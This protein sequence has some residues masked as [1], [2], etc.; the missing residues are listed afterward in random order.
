MLK[1][2]SSGLRDISLPST[3]ISARKDMWQTYRSIGSLSSSEVKKN[4]NPII[5]EERRLY[6]PLGLE[7][8]KFSLYNNSSPISF[9]DLGYDSNM[10][11]SPP[12]SFFNTYLRLNYYD[13]QDP[14][15]KRLV[16]Q[17]D[18]PFSYETSNV[19]PASPVFFVSNKNGAGKRHG[20][21]LYYFDVE[22]DVDLFLETLFLDARV[23]RSI[24]LA[25][26]NAP[27]SVEDI[28][29]AAFIKIPVYK[30]SGDRFYGLDGQGKEFV[31]NGEK[32]EIKLF[33]IN[34]L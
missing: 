1:I 14:S 17:A 26:Y 4:I 21:Y 30:I 5:D 15:S 29:F 18:L 33:E 34:V 13:S 28:P 27:V 23:G 10:L 12:L 25:S 19:E 20:F 11:S 32:L 31:H 16:Y 3:Y 24:R 8:I 22:G 9:F 6:A 7:E 2:R